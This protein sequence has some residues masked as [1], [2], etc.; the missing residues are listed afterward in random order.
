M[1]EQSE[2]W[3]DWPQ[4]GYVP[5][6][7]VNYADSEDTIG[8]TEVANASN[9]LF[10]N[11]MA[12]TRPGLSS[13][14]TTNISHTAAFAKGLAA[15]QLNLVIDSSGLLWKVT[16]AGVG[17]QIT[18]AGTSF[19]AGVNPMVD[20]VNNVVLIGGNSGGLI[21]WNP[22]GT[23]YTVLTPGAQ[24]RYVAG[25]LARAVAAYGITGSVNDPITF[26]YSVP[27]DQTTWTGST[28]GSGLIVLSDAPD[29]ITGLGV[30]HNIVVL[31]RATGF[32][33]AY[34]TGQFAP[35]FQ[36]QT[37][38]RD[39]VG[40]PYPS[41]ISFRN[42]LMFFVG[43]DDVYVF[44]L[45]NVTS[46]GRNIRNKLFALL[47][48]GS[49]IIG[50]TTYH[51]KNSVGQYLPC[52]RYHLV[53]LG[54]NTTHFCYNFEAKTWSVH[55]YAIGVSEWPFDFVGASLPIGQDNGFSL[56]DNS[57]P[58][59]IYYWDAAVACEQP[60]SVTSKLFYVGNDPTTDYTLQRML[61][62]NR[63]LGGT[64]VTITATARLATNPVSFN[65]AQAGGLFNTG[66]LIRTWFDMMVDGVAT[67][68]GQGYQTTVNIPANKAFAFNYLLMRL[69][70]AG[71]YRG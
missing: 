36:I 61:L 26:A 1:P 28:N 65:N 49:N 9:F 35:T 59:K 54:S 62:S 53:A 5:T 66:Y 57:V 18:G 42:N 71:E 16:P 44:D 33:L 15:L 11:G 31:P 67:G 52:L 12:L 69:T 29:V 27:G 34:Y 39:G 43:P 40:A 14:T 58:A 32:H 20:I 10:E 37:Y 3:I 13:V 46:I 63:D 4:G 21:Q 38:T 6:G 60:S 25:Q 50:F 30:M 48:S 7:G 23:T 2:Q 55:S 70:E 56:A 64:G 41:T 47:N 51:M 17:T 19:A 68:V 45:T 24:Y 22:S 8:D